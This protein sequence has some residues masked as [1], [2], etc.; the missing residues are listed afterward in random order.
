M[1]LMS[2]KVDRPVG[3]RVLPGPPH[4]FLRW[5]SAV[6]RL[7][8]TLDKAPECVH[9]LAAG[10]LSPCPLPTPALIK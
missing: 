5:A 10:G 3:D 2:A 7:M 6:R 9:G 4:A 1:P 8:V